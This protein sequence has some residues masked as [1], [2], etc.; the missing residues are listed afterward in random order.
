MKK[1]SVDRVAEIANNE[2]KDTFEQADLLIL[3]GASAKIVSRFF[4]ETGIKDEDEQNIYDTVNI[5]YHRAQK[6]YI[7]F[8]A[9]TDDEEAQLEAQVDFYEQTEREVECIYKVCKIFDKHEWQ[10]YEKRLCDE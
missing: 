2:V 6:N 1:P 8:F 9:D 4:E 3:A 5:I 10:L 7:R